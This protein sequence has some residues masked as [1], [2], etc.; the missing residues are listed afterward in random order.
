MEEYKKLKRELFFY[1]IT[2][3]FLIGAMIFFSYRSFHFKKNETKSFNSER[4]PS[5]SLPFYEEIM[6]VISHLEYSGFHAIVKPEVTAS[7]NF[8]QRTWTIHNVHKF[9]KNNELILEKG[10]Y[11]LCGEL[12][13]YTY[14][15]IKAFLK[16]D[17]AIIFVRA[18]ESG[19]FLRPFSSHIVLAI[20]NRQTGERYYLD[21]S[22]QRYGKEEDFEDYLFFEPVDVLA[23][24][25]EQV[26]DVSFSVNSGTPLLIR[27]NFILYLTVEP[28]DGNFDKDNF[29][30]AVT[31]NKRYRYSGRYLF[32]L[33]KHHGKQEAFQNAWLLNQLLKPEEATL[34]IDEM[35]RWFEKNA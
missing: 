3:I 33:R 8:D 24:L 12:A 35:T 34:L 25:N 31:A 29:I 20:I 14:K 11:G 27:N 10:R 4:Q 19:F 22:F 28:V 13:A 9:D 16:D 6:N 23:I 1:R 18:A 5:Q 30:L 2:L 17:Y 26:A 7:I 21:P 15:K 32:A